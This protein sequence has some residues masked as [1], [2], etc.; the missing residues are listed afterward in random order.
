MNVIQRIVDTPNVSASMPSLLHG[1]TDDKPRPVPSSSRI[2]DSAAAAAPPA[3]T[4]PHETAERGLAEVST[5]AAATW[6]PPLPNG[7]LGS[8][9]ALMERPSRCLQCPTDCKKRATIRGGR[10][11]LRGRELSDERDEAADGIRRVEP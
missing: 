8:T 2:S 3:N 4:A 1:E 6:P 7:P 9:I 10:A 5:A 11:P